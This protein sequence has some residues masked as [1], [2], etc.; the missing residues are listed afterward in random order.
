[1]SI[2]RPTSRDIEKNSTLAMNFTKVSLNQAKAGVTKQLLTHRKEFD[3]LKSYHTDVSYHQNKLKNYLDPYLRSSGEFLSHESRTDE[4]DQSQGNSYDIVS[5]TKQL[6]GSKLILESFQELSLKTPLLLSTSSF[7]LNYGTHR[8]EF[9]DISQSTF[10]HLWTRAIDTISWLSDSQNRFITGWDIKTASNEISVTG[11]KRH[12]ADFFS[13][14]VGQGEEILHRNKTNLE[15]N[16]GNF[17]SFI[18]GSRLE[19]LKEGDWLL[20]LEQGNLGILTTGKA[21][22]FS[23]QD[24]SIESTNNTYISGSLVYINTSSLGLPSS[25]QVLEKSYEEIEDLPEYD[26]NK[27][28][29]QVASP[30]YTDSEGNTYLQEPPSGK[31]GGYKRRRRSRYA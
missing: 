12:Y 10:H 6:G 7:F 24:T 2:N 21:T 20:E 19:R 23:K 4:N 13:L 27:T 16:Y 29:K 5:G 3:L 31:S 25:P 17:S 1:M 15:G 22:Y 28:P 9:I 26:H 30:Y 8:H 11:N 14:Q 18:Q